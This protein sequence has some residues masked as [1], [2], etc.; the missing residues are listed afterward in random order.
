MNKIIPLMQREWLQHRNGWLLLAGVPL[1][2][3]LLMLITGVGTVQFDAD[4]IENAG[5]A[6]PTF[7]ALATMFGTAVVIFAILWLSSLLIGSGLARRDHADRSVEFW[8]SLPTS[9]TQSLGVPLLVH[10]ILVPAA[11]L[12]VGLLGGCVVSAMAVARLGGIADLAS[13]PWGQVIA[14][15]TAFTLRTMAGLVLASLWLSPLIML[16]VLLGAWFRRWAWVILAVGLGLGG[17]ILKQ[18]FGQPIVSDLT[19]ALF[20][21]ASK[22][23]FAGGFGAPTIHSSDE[24]LSVLRFAPGWALEDLGLALSNLA[25]PLFVGALLFS[26]GCFY[27]LVQWRQRGAGA[28]D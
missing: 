4:T 18:A 13:V 19:Q 5:T 27:L 22:A 25:S 15:S 28:G 9:H 20:K 24:A 7:M 8:L 6:F 21:Q 12:L 2:L 3:T 14:A 1:L 11:A 17:V 10:L 23:F 26:A 16:T